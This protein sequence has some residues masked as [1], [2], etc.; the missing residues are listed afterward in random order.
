MTFLRP[1]LATACL[2]ALP[3]V[4]GLAAAAGWF[5]HAAHISSTATTALSAPSPTPITVPAFPA[6]QTV[7]QVFSL[8]NQ[9]RGWSH[10]G[11]PPSSIRAPRPRG[12]ISLRATT[13]A[14]ASTI[15]N[16]HGKTLTRPGTTIARPGRIWPRGIRRAKLWCKAGCSAQPIGRT[17]SNRSTATLASPRWMG[18]FLAPPRPDSWS[19]T[20]GSSRDVKSVTGPVAAGRA[21]PRSRRHEHRCPN[22][23]IDDEFQISTGS[24]WD[25]S[26]P[27]PARS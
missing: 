2:I 24:S 1:T 20:S 4:W 18:G 3:F 17:S 16:H 15:T 6:P 7:D 5:A 19:R 12:R 10:C 9:E 26:A 27:K 22:V 11:D 23:D 14:T 8:V 21:T 25:R 13:G